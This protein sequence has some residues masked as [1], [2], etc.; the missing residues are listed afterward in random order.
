MEPP[1]ALRV[2]HPCRQNPQPKSKLKPDTTF[3][4]RYI[5]LRSEA[6]PANYPYLTP[7]VPNLYAN[8]GIHE[9]IPIPFFEF[10]GP[11][12]PPGDIGGPGDVYID[13]AA[14]ALYSKSE[15]D[16]TKWAGPDT[17]ES[18]A[19]PHFVDSRSARF[20]WFHP[21]DGVEWVSGVTFRRRR[22]VWREDG[23][24]MSAA[25]IILGYLGLASAEPKSAPLPK[26]R[27]ARVRLGTVVD[28]DSDSESGSVSDTAFYPSKKARLLESASAPLPTTRSSASDPDINRL[29]KERAALEARRDQLLQ[30]QRE[31]EAADAD[32]RTQRARGI[33]ERLEK[34]YEKYR[35]LPSL[36][37]AEFTE[38]ILDLHSRLL[39]AQTTLAAKQQ[40]RAELERQTAERLQICED[41]KKKQEQIRALCGL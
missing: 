8:R 17:E 6:I 34:Q 38:R 26:R 23:A 12:A 28:A 3:T 18:P 24:R 19:H 29:R 5:K 4:L 11:G 32:Q 9:H 40:E 21:A 10:R 36:T 30:R 20:I 16:W 33:L 14:G 1:L 13:T 39:T 7:T 25:Q 31:L 35:S 27:A 15:E 2:P 22:D 37:E 41:R